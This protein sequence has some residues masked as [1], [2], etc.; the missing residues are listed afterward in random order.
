M[1]VLLISMVIDGG[2]NKCWGL[3]VNVGY[4]NLWFTMLILGKN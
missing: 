1:E 3:L 2:T 4:W